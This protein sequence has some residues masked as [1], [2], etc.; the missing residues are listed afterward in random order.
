MILHLLSNPNFF[1]EIIVQFEFA[2]SQ[3]NIYIVF[4]KDHYE[5]INSLNFNIPIV[6][7]KTI[8]NL[9]HIQ[10][11]GV[12]AHFLTEASANLIVQLP[13]K[14]PILWA[15]Y[16]IDLYGFFPQMR[17]YKYG[18]H[19]QRY[20]NSQRQLPN[21]L[22]VIKEYAYYSFLF[23]NRLKKKALKKIS[24]YSTV[25][26]FEKEIFPKHLKK[27]LHYHHISIGLFNEI[28]TESEATFKRSSNFDKNSVYIGNS[29]SPTCNHLDVLEKLKRIEFTPKVNVTLQVSYGGD[30]YYVNE[31]IRQYKEVFKEKVYF[32]KEWINK[33][34][35]YELLTSYNVYI[36]GTIRQQGMGAVYRA[37]WCGGK[38]YLSKTNPA[39]SF[40]KSLGIIVFCIEDDLKKTYYCTITSPLNSEDVVE[41]RQILNSLYS[42]ETNIKRVKN[43]LNIFYQSS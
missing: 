4:N 34:E 25:I 9:N 41:N 7:F 15:C 29:A 40:L 3:K 42:T 19:T 38:V 6:Y 8:N 26:P 14:A 37:L 31:L 18:K 24:Y 36:F 30:K 43:L 39:Y 1:N 12:I 35:F 20:I 2:N 13:S 16:G 28:F 23:K 32:I 11:D 21:F 17:K 10:I 22:H 5:R 33:E 27:R